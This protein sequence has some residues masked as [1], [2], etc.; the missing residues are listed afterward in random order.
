[1]RD[2]C[3]ASNL[4]AYLL[5][6]RIAGVADKLWSAFQRTFHSDIRGT[7]LNDILAFG[8]SSETQAHLRRST[9]VGR[10]VKED[11]KHVQLAMEYLGTRNLSS[12]YR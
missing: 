8:Q 1:M 4:A 9:A 11:K 7:R 6:S 12:G 3:R 5:G 2:A 10:Q